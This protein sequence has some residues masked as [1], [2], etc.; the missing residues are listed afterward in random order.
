MELLI[1][2]DDGSTTKFTEDMAV[3]AIK[4]RDKLRADLETQTGRAEKYWDKV[5][6]IRRLV[7]GFFNDGYEPGESVIEA[8]VGDINQLLR[9][10]GADTLKQ[11][12]TV[13]GTI[14]FSIT[15]VEAESEE[16]AQDTVENYL[17]VEWDSEGSLDDWSI[18][19]D[20]VSEQ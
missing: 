14:N 17:R 19:V 10:I 7:F 4:E 2:N 18:E 13:R 5:T 8:S 12:Y 20:R 3:T 1:T 9:D 15:D 16:D 6:E 11:M